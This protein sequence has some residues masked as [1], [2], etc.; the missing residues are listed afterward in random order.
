MMV[1]SAFAVTMFII[2]IGGKCVNRFPIFRPKMFLRRNTCGGAVPEITIPGQ[3][4]ASGGALWYN[5]GNNV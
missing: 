4:L 1:I 3:S 2:A 5:R